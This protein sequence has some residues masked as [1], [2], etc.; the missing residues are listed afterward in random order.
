[1]RMSAVKRLK[2]FEQIYTDHYKQIYSTCLRICRNEETAEDLTHDT[3]VKVFKGLRKFRGKCKVSTWMT[4]IAIFESLIA[5]RGLKNNV[6]HF[7]IDAL[8]REG[9]KFDM[10]RIDNN[11]T[12]VVEVEEL[13]R[14]IEKLRPK[15]KEALFLHSIV[16]YEYHE[17]GEMIGICTN[18]AKARVRRGRMA[19]TELLH[20]NQGHGEEVQ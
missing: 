6:I 18:T 13:Y 1:M 10:P 12:N 4:R 19:L 16:G 7:S 2:Y 3:F 11:L 14:A 9:N 8:D 17:V 5:K 15:L 20:E